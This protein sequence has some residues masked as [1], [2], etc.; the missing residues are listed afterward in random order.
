MK[1]SNGFVVF[2]IIVIE[3]L[4]VCYGSIEKGLMQTTNL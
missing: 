4:G 3:L 1:W 2:G